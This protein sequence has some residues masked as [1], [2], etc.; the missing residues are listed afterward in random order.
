[1]I[2]A[3]AQRESRAGTSGPERRDRSRTRPSVRRSSSDSRA[4]CTVRPGR[5]CWCAGRPTPTPAAR[6]TRRPWRRSEHS[7]PTAITRPGCFVMGPLSTPNMWRRPEQPKKHSKKSGGRRLGGQLAPTA[8]HLEVPVR[9]VL[10]AARLPGQPEGPLAEDV[11]LDLVGPAAEAVARA[12]QVH[13][14]Q[15]AL[16]GGRA[17]PSASRALRR[18][19]RR[20]RGTAGRC[21]PWSAWRWNRRPR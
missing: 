13:H 21:G 6:S 17:G 16:Q 8:S 18:C 5:A 11:E 3:H 4:T 14:L 10:V 1:M 7:M 12:G 19:G 20:G 9:H 15:V 2:R